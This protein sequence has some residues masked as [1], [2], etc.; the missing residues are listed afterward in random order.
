MANRIINRKEKGLILPF[1]EAFDPVKDP[2]LKLLKQPF[3]I[4]RA[5]RE[6]VTERRSMIRMKTPVMDIVQRS[7]ESLGGQGIDDRNEMLD[8]QFRKLQ[9]QP[10]REE[11]LV[12]FLV[13]CSSIHET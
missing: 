10:Q 13:M 5:F 6:K 4:P 7:R 2:R 11:K 9:H 3:L 8:D 12:D 1:G